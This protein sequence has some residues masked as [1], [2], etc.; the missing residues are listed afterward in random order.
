MLRKKAKK[1]AEGGTLPRSIFADFEGEGHD[2]LH[3]NRWSGEIDIQLTTMTPLVFGEQKKSSNRNK[4]STVRLPVD[5]NG[6][7][8]IPPTMIKGMI[9]RAYETLT[10]SR[11]RIFEDRS[12]RLTYRADAAEALR[13]IPIR[14]TEHRGNG[15]LEAELLCGASL[16]EYTDDSTTYPIMPAACLQGVS[17]SSNAHTIISLDGGLAELQ[18]MAPHGKRLCCR[19]ALC[20]HPARGKIGPYAYW[21][22]THIQPEDHDSMIEVCR[23][24]SEIHVVKDVSV[25]ASGYVYRTARDGRPASDV[26]SGKHDERFFFST[27]DNPPIRVMIPRQVAEG[28]KAIA[29]GYLAQRKDEEDRKVTGTPQ[30]NRITDEAQRSGDSGRRE[31]GCGD[32]AYATLSDNDYSRSMNN[33]EPPTVLEVVPTMVGRRAYPLSPRDLAEAQEVLPLSNRGEA[34]AADRLFGYVVKTTVDGAEGGA[35]ALRGR[36]VVGPVDT[37]KVEVQ[38]KSQLLAPLLSPKPTSARRFITDSEGRTPTYRG[39]PL[40]R[41]ACYSEGQLLG[42]AAYPVNRNNLENSGFPGTAK[43]AGQSSDGDSSGESLCF[44]VKDWIGTGNV[45]TCTIY[46]TDVEAEELAALL[47][48]LCPNNLVPAQEKKGNP[49]AQGFLRMG[50]GKPLGLGVIKVEVPENGVRM[51]TGYDLSRQYRCLTGCLGLPGASKEPPVFNDDLVKTLS[52][53]PWVKAMQRAAYGYSDG[54]VVRYMNLDENKRN[55]RTKDGHPASGAGFSPRNLADDGQK[56]LTIE[57]GQP[58]STR[59]RR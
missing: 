21:Q 6:R 49:D 7:V 33:T 47:W 26:F 2:H 50:L 54:V 4:A 31:L 57:D 10:A 20:L 25:E 3:P 18:K 56:P 24:K 44:R 36:I 42:A 46:I 28:Y 51:T 14:V 38:A 55:N 12:Q 52:D 45:M 9:S 32:L 19:M 48:V 23:I 59:H 5:E 58:S 1:G 11:F 35:V 13:L 39:R 41:T 29:D 22:V 17:D 43:R 53:M 15:D 30:Y 34:S 27:S 37:T 16:R 40:P 8:I